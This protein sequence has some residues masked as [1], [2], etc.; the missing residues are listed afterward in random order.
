MTRRAF[1][2][3]SALVPAVVVMGGVPAALSQGM[4][5]L[6]QV[7][8]ELNTDLFS[9]DGLAVPIARADGFKICRWTRSYSRPGRGRRIL[10]R[11]VLWILP[12]LVR[13]RRR[14]TVAG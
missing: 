7:A 13:A 3:A 4:P 12:W 8:D 6:A 10:R 11:L 5:P 2:K 14:C 9:S 1:L